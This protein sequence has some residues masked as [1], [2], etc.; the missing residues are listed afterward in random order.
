MKHGGNRKQNKR[1]LQIVTVFILTLIVTSAIAAQFLLRPDKNALFTIVYTGDIQGAVSYAPGEHAGYEKIAAI[2]ASEEAECKTILIDAGGCLGG[3]EIAEADSGASMI[4]LMNEAGYDALVPGPKDF[5]YGIDALLA[6]RSEASFPFLAANLVRSDGTRLFE[7]YAVI[8]DGDVRIGIVGVTN[9]ISRQAAERASVTVLDPVETVAA[10]VGEL[11][12]RTDAVIVAA[13]TGNEEITRQIAELDG[14]SLVIESGTVMA[15]RNQTE[16]GTNIVSAG[17]NGETVGT[18]HIQIRRSKVSVELA[19]KIPE[20]FDAAASDSNI[21]AAV[22]KCMKNKQAKESEIVGV[23]ETGTFGQAAESGDAESGD[24][25]GKTNEP[26]RVETPTGDM[27]TD[28]MLF[29]A[30]KDGAE[31]ALIRGKNIK[32]ELKDGSVTRGELNALFDD[33]LN[34]VTCKM[35]GGELR[36]LLEDSFDDYPATDNC[37]Q[38]AGL[39]LEYSTST[40]IG[41]AL[42]EI[43]VGSHSLDDARIYTVSVTNDLLESQEGSGRDVIAYYNCMGSIMNS[44]VSQISGFTLDTLPGPESDEEETESDDGA[45]R[46]KII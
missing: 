3:S 7:N 28:A 21:V 25:D 24:A 23:F 41:S 29:A 45:S 44:Y 13:Y 8:S 10:A 17:K 31:I 12:R 15:A 37:F 27:V 16:N 35:T 32:G 43:I 40:D 18:A 5:V 6:L 30:S 39:R 46:I 34:M 9:G 36:K 22:E 11:E 4:S 20:H 19:D 1:F 33:S 14:V 42:S 26:V 2:N 38:V